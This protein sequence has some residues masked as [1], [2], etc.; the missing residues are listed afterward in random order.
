[1]ALSFFAALLLSAAISPQGAHSVIIQERFDKANLGSGWHRSVSAG[2]TVEVKDGA[3]EIG[4]RRNTFANVSHPIG[5][6]LVTAQCRIK[7]APAESWAT[8][9]FLYWGAA[10]WCQLGIKPMDGGRIYM[11]QMAN[12][13]YSEFN[14]G[15]T[16]FDSWRYL[17]IELGKDVMRFYSSEDSAKWRIETFTERPATFAGAPAQLILGKG[18]GGA[19]GYAKPLL[20]NDYADKG[21]FGTSLIDDVLVIPTPAARAH[22]NPKER[23]SWAYMLEDGLGKEMLALPGGPTFEAIAKRLPGILRPREVVGVPEHPYDIGVGWDGTI[24]LKDWLGDTKMPAA[25]LE[26]GDPP[27]RVGSPA[28]PVAKH[29]E[30]GGIPLVILSF[31]H[32]GIHFVARVFGWSPGMSPDAPLSA[33]LSVAAKGRSTH[34]RPFKLRLNMAPA[35]AGWS[36]IEWSGTATAGKAVTF[37]AKADR[38]PAWGGFTEVPVDDL[39]S[40]MGEYLQSWEDRLDQGLKLETPERQVNDSY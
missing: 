13:I 39:A 8:S 31:D 29:L 9:I 10:D 36:P 5:T 32:D 19:E 21:E 6:D 4:A 20:A 1:M 30:P 26:V 11:T 24:Q 14:L 17:R 25:F 28:V 35:P 18:Y 23:G 22:A 27:V 37:C 40:K 33:C 38:G 16:P 3:L 7:P 15:Q 34:P 12:G 2:N